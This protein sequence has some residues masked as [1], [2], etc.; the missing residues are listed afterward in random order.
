MIDAEPQ[1]GKRAKRAASLRIKDI[2]RS[3]RSIANPKGGL[4]MFGVSGLNPLEMFLA[5][6]IPA[7]AVRG[8]ETVDMRINDHS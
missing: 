8:F 7:G 4:M 3:G 2:R 6:G 5:A 1:I